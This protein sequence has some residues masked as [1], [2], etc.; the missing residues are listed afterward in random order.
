MRFS[1]AYQS[2]RIGFTNAGAASR[3]TRLSAQRS[4]RLGG[5][6]HGFTLVELLVV[7][8]IIG[9]LVALLLPAIQAARAA[10]RRT[11][12]QSNLKQIGIALHNFHD[13]NKEFPAG[14]EFDRRILP[15]GQEFPPLASSTPKFRPN[16]IIR[17][18]PYLEEQPLFDSFHPDSFDSTKKI[19]I[20][21][22]ENRQAR[23]TLIP[24]LLCPE[25]SG[26]AVPFAGFQPT[27]GDNWARG[28]YAC[29]GDNVNADGPNADTEDG[30]PPPYGIV[31]KN[32]QRIGVM[33]INTN[34]KISQI[35]DGTSHTLLAA[36]VRIGLNEFDRRGTWAMGASG[37]SNLTW[38][39]FAGD[40]NGPNPSNEES[41]DILGCGKVI[42]T[43]GAQ[44]LT[45]ERMTCW[46]PCPSYQ[47]APRSRHAPGGVHGVM[48]DGSV[49]WISD[50]VNTTGPWG[51][52]CGVWDRLVAARD[53]VPVELQW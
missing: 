24:T 33:R 25:D 16:W 2:R 37:A 18:L 14:M 32:P 5:L 19:Y 13:A 38:H 1:Y 31:T 47:A 4:P 10:A 9:I 23:G 43:L 29:N 11:Q 48:A 50:D 30:R 20:S 7:I 39:G 15:S 22:P 3:S 51:A 44:T 6:T 35:I 8:A 45:Q 36:E 41:D 40:C 46:Q 28:N 26:S 17:I 52:C 21:S 49:H 53:G 12:C 42:L 27:E 34:S